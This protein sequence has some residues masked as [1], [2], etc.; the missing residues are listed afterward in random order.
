MPLSAL[1]GLFGMNVSVWSFGFWAVL[2]FALMLG[3]GLRSWA[4]AGTSSDSSDS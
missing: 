2:L 3:L 4:V 1:T